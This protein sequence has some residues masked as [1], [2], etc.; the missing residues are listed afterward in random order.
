M[1]NL[2]LF[3][4][5]NGDRPG[6]S[7]EKPVWTDRMVERRRSK[8]VEGRWIGKM[9]STVSIKLEVYPLTCESPLYVTPH[10]QIRHKSQIQKLRFCNKVIEDNTSFKMAKYLSFYHN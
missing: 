10:H 8:L 9:G 3:A 5:Q 4:G 6:V 2:T 7:D 1:P